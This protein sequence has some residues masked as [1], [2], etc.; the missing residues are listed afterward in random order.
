MLKRHKLFLICFFAAP[1]LLLTSSLIPNPTIL[2][3]LEFDAN[4][5]ALILENYPPAKDGSYLSDRY[6]ECVAIT[7]G[8][9]PSRD[10]S[11]FDGLKGEFIGN[12]YDL[13]ITLHKPPASV[14]VIAKRFDSWKKEFGWDG[15]LNSRGIKDKNTYREMILGGEFSSVKIFDEVVNFFNSP[16]T[17]E[18]RLRFTEQSA[19]EP[20]PYVR[21]WHGYQIITRPS[22]AIGGVSFLR[23]V[24]GGFFLGSVLLV[25]IFLA[26]KY[27]PSIAI[28]FCVLFLLSI[29]TREI[30]SN[31]IHAIGMASMMVSAVYA[32]RLNSAKAKL[33]CGFWGMYFSFLLN[34]QVGLLMTF[35]LSY[36]LYLL[37]SRPIIELKK[38]LQSSILW[39]GGVLLSF[40][41]KFVISL[42]IL[43]HKEVTS[44]FLSAIENRS[45]GGD[46]GLNDVAYDFLAMMVLNLR[47]WFFEGWRSYTLI[48]FCFFAI[49]FQIAH[50]KY[51]KKYLVFDLICILLV[52]LS[53]FGILNH[54]LLHGLFVW[55]VLPTLAVIL[56]VTSIIAITDK[57]LIVTS[58]N[59]Y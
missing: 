21:F 33:M 39:G 48:G 27:T 24:G 1:L 12:C 18:S 50:I 7:M 5:G 40:V 13:A 19:I 54:S 23:I 30:L 55:R 57:K 42:L 4:R 35:W 36:D 15:V 8:I 29:D 53:L 16:P 59:S 46:H 38:S 31:S 58:S 32:A 45:W 47:F 49:V 22:I 56:S 2:N 52:L 41:Y 11:L 14:D 43:S 25:C 20:H 9:N 17:L 26:K 28:T 10:Q 37:N 3:H 51:Y 34:I 6:T 44:I